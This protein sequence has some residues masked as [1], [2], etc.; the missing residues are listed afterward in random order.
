MDDLIIFKIWAHLPDPFPIGLVL[1]F[2]SRLRSSY[3]SSRSRVSSGGIVSGYGLEDRAIDIRSPAEAKDFSS[4]L[5]VQTGSEAHP[6]S[7]TMGTGVHFP[8]GKARPR[9]DNDH[10][11][12]IKCRGREWVGAMPPLP[13]SASM[14]C[15]GIALPFFYISS[16]FWFIIK[17]L[18][19]QTV[20]IY[21]F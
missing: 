14:A 11:P 8:G 15:S 7:C 1:N 9:R 16:A 12:T 5:S 19:I 6:A 2:P 17:W 20:V 13:P 18:L 10:S 3:T 21:S 4:S